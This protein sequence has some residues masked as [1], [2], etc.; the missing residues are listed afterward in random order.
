MP[1]S[2]T[3]LRR[4][5]GSQTERWSRRAS[6]SLFSACQRHQLIGRHPGP[7]P[8]RATHV[9]E[10]TLP[11]C[12][13]RPRLTDDDAASGCVELDLAVRK[14]PELLT[15]ALRNRHLALGSNAHGNTPCSITLTRQGLLRCCAETR[16][17]SVSRRSISASYAAGGSDE[18]LAFRFA[19]ADSISA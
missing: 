8:R 14:K 5:S 13:L 3:S 18:R 15:N 10:Q 16:A 19:I 6:P 17:S 2:R 11:A 4:R 12:R 1:T 9:L 7:R